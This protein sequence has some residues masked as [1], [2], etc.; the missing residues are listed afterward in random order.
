MYRKAGLG[1][2]LGLIL[3][4]YTGVLAFGFASGATCALVVVIN[5]K[6]TNKQEVLK[7]MCI[8]RSLIKK[9]IDD[10]AKILFEDRKGFQPVRLLQHNA[11]KVD[12]LLHRILYDTQEDYRVLILQA[13]VIPTMAHWVM[14]KSRFF[15]TV[16]GLKATKEKKQRLH[17]QE[18]GLLDGW[19]SFVVS[20]V[21][22]TRH[23][24]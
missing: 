18:M 19:V 9:V 15:V 7:R 17:P 11:M 1:S 10:K 12:R 5:S 24:D 8:I 3:S 21:Q 16:S 20:L 13:R 2:A 22:R 23:H 4:L 6:H 14:G